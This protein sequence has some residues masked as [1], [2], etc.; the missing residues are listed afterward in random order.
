MEVSTSFSA[1]ELMISPYLLM[2]FN[3][4]DFALPPFLISRE[5]LSSWMSVISSS[6][7]TD[8]LKSTD[9]LSFLLVRVIVYTAAFV[10]LILSPLKL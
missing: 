3:L 9:W 5:A 2:K 7:D 8:T 1:L 10:A 4:T 6:C